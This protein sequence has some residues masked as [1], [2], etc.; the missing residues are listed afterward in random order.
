MSQAEEFSNRAIDTLVERYRSRCLWFLRPDFY[1]TTDAERLRV[2]DYIGRY[3][4]VDA[5]QRAARLKQ[6][7]LQRSNAP[8]AA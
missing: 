5:F 4:D 8:S 1:P 2:L 3:G 7:L 6:W